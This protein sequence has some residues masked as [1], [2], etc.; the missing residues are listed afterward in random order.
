ML[1]FSV[2][3]LGENSDIMCISIRGDLTAENCEYLL[4]CVES[5]IEDGYKNLI[6]NCAGLTYIS[7]LGLGMLVRVHSRMKKLDGDVRLAG[8]HGKVAD[9]LNIVKLDRVFQ[10]YPNEVEAAASFMDG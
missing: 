8:L 10:I 4:K 3:A 9:I 2:E 7:S 1:D 5:Q 6:L